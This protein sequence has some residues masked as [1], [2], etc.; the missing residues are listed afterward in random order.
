M[1]VDHLLSSSTTDLARLLQC[2]FCSYLV[3]QRHLSQHTIHSYRDTFRLLL[4]FIATEQSNPVPLLSLADININRILSFLHYL[5]Q[6][7]GCKA[8]TRNARLSAV[9]SFFNYVAIEE[10][11]RLADTQKILAIPDKRTDR[12]VFEYLEKRE[13]DALLLTQD[14]TN[15]T[16]K[17]DHIMLL[18]LYNT[19]ARVSEITN[20]QIKDIDLKRQQAIHLHGKGRKERIIPLWPQTTELKNGSLVCRIHHILPFFQTVTVVKYHALG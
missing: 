10:P 17:R 1:D 20:L 14:V 16:G 18:T 13:I 11:Q 4:M 15:W 12:F 19:D 3:N 8:K 2:Y 9:R 7:R 5:E 6:K